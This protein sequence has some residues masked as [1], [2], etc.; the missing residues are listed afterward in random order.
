MKKHLIDF[1]ENN[2]SIESF[3][4]RLRPCY[5][6]IMQFGDRVL[7]AQMN[8]NGMLE[9]AVYGFVEDPEEGWS[10]IECRLELLKISD[11]TYT[12]AGHAIEW[13]I[14]SRAP[15]GAFA[16]SGGFFQCGNIHK[17][18]KKRCV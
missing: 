14:K 8:W 3:Y 15:S 2:I 18:D 6:S 13:C 1:P 12:D 9:G 4:E 5:D 16:R 11:E 7:V 10:P 17:S